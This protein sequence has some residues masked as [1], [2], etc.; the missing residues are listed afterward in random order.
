MEFSKFYESTFHNV[1]GFFSNLGLTRVDIED[2]TQESYLILYKN[3]F[4]REGLEE[5]EMSKILFGICKNQ[6][7]DFVKKN[8]GRY[9]LI[10]SVE[11]VE[12]PDNYPEALFFAK[13]ELEYEERVHQLKL[14]ISKALDTTKGKVRE[15]LK[16]R[17][18]DGKTRKEVSRLLMISEK[19]VH[20]Y[21]KRGI[22]YI[23]KYLLIK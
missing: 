12:D 16:Y 14:Q 15:V 8:I 6:Y 3:Y 4:F 7:R 22:K 5:V 2:L 23:K 1:V 13:D 18:I 21:Q 19:D 10:E 11:L 17:F 20:T 9:N